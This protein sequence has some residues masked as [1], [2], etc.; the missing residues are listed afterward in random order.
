[1]NPD[2]FYD[3]NAPEVAK[4]WSRRLWTEYRK[5]DAVLDPR[6]GFAGPNE[7]YLF[8]HINEAENTIG[9]EVTTNYSFQIANEPG[10]RGNNVLEGKEGG[11]VTEVYKIKIDKLRHGVKTMGEMN[12]QRVH[13]NTME[14]GKRKLHD[15]WRTRRAVGI[16]N[17]LCGNTAQTDERFTGLA[18]VNA[19]DSE[20]IFRPNSLATDELVAADPTAKFDVPIVEEM[21]ARAEQMT[22]AIRPFIYKGN[23]YYIMFL[24]SNQVSDLRDSNSKW[25][26]TMQNGLKGG[27]RDEN[28]LFGRALGMWRQTL[29]ITEPYLTQGVHS[30]NGTSVPNTRRAVFC[31][32]GCLGMAYGRHYRGGDNPFRWFSST[33]DHGDKYYCSAGLVFGCSAVRLPVN[34]VNRDIGKIVI[35]TYSVERVADAGNLGQ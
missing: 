20:H 27:L 28:P 3:T 24:H 29:F 25:Y 21:I 6:H 1:M 18:P 13:F 9:D 22:P 12:E 2:L 26:E 4:V 23:A 17:Q 31:G 14:E 19:P 16:A 7:D 35:P 34:G 5:K 10:V 30:V 15:W 33:W 8:I 32:A 11:T